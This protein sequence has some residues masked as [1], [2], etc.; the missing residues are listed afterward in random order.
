MMDVFGNGIIFISI[1]RDLIS[2][3]I[4]NEAGEIDYE[5]LAKSI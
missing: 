2:V 1:S 3:G 5:Q 4:L